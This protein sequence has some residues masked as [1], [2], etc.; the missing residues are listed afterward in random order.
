M[1]SFLLLDDIKNEFNSG[2]SNW[3]LRQSNLV[4]GRMSESEDLIEKYSN[5]KISIGQLPPRNS[6]MQNEIESDFPFILI[7]PLDGSLDGEKQADYEIN[8]AIVCGIY[9]R[10]SRELYE[11][12]V[13]DV[14]N[15][16]DRLLMILASKRFWA[17]N[18][19]K[20]T[21]ELKWAIGATRAHGAYEAGM[22]EQGP[23]FQMVIEAPF[24]RTVIVPEKPILETF[25]PQIIVEVKK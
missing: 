2:L 15:L 19:F 8:V 24:E 12:G 7:R 4:N 22:Q 10:E 21:G 20:R 14:M 17:D 3:T 23:F 6:N 1:D 5:P 25:P 13:Q 18:R 16:N 9:S 11:H